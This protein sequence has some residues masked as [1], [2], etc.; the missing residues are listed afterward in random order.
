[1][2]LGVRAFR[3]GVAGCP[4]MVTDHKRIQIAIVENG[5]DVAGLHTRAQVLHHL[6]RVEHVAAN[7]VT[8][9]DRG[10]GSTNL[11]ECLGA[12]LELD[13]VQTGLDT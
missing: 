5:L 9:T 4:A 2:C 6:I 10:L 13:L 12:L 3:I 8:K 1:M 7:L 11:V